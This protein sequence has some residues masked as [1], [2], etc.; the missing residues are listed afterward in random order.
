MK[1]SN[2][3]KN[4]VMIRCFRDIELKKKEFRL[5]KAIENKTMIPEGNI[6]FSYE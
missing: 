3:N 2:F 1:Q 5:K 6:I 4:T